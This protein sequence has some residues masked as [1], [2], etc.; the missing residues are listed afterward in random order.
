MKVLVATKE[1]LVFDELA[2]RASD[3]EL[4]AALDTGR[5]YA[6]IPTAQLAIID[7]RDLVPH[8]YSTD[9][10]RRLLSSATLRQCSSQEFL[11]SPEAYLSGGDARRPSQRSGS[12][13]WLPW[14]P[15][16]LSSR[17]FALPDKRTIALTS[18]SGGTG[19]TSLALDTAL[20]F[21]AQTEH[22]LPLPVSV[23]EFTYGGSALNALIRSDAPPV[24]ELMRQPELEPSS[25]HGVTLYPMEY[26]AM[27]PIPVDR[28]RRYLQ[29]QMS[30]HVLNVIDA[31][32]PHGAVSLIGDDVDLWIVLTTPRIDA[33]ENARKL[34][35]RLAAE[36][37]EDKVVIAVNQMGG[38]GASLSLLGFDRDIEIPR[39]QEAEVFFGGRIG[40]QILGHTY[41]SLW[42]DYERAGRRGRRLFRR[43]S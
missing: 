27:R 26:D 29:E 22:R 18:F 14:R 34:Q 24:D 33:V 42:D 28:V 8:P 23:F 1:P 6:S 30:N 43:R 39:I 4:I 7:Y 2:N 35:Q 41:N 40:K 13:R 38:L 15:R 32:W 11:A 9:C 36:Y 16:S 17:A 10:I 5:L 21:A 25:F 20:H 31:I 37:G 19:K 3:A 12:R